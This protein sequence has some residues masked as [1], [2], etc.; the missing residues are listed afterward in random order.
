MTGSYVARILRNKIDIW[1]NGFYLAFKID[2]GFAVF[3]IQQSSYC[4]S[5]WGGK[6]RRWKSWA[7]L[8]TPVLAT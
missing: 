1:K 5:H 4:H 3:L 6:D 7:S 8:G 2:T